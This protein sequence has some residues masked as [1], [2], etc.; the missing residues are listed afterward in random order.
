MLQ[1]VSALCWQSNAWSNPKIILHLLQVPFFSF[2][3]ST[4]V[5]GRG[6]LLN[7]EYKSQSNFQ[8]TLP[9]APYFK[10]K[11]HGSTGQVT[12]PKAHRLAIQYT[13]ELDCHVRGLHLTLLFPQHLTKPCSF[14]MMSR[15]MQNIQ[16]DWNETGPF[17]QQLR[18]HLCQYSTC[19][20]TLQISLNLLSGPI[21]ISG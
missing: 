11:A 6:W 8:S 18:H 15:F 13:V 10:D 20:T 1:K 16:K 4:G 17:P 3:Q 5:N 2:N 19:S 21:L 9:T 7:P 12:R 14:T